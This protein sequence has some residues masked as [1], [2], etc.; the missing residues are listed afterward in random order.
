[1]TPEQLIEALN[2]MV[3][4]QWVVS[5]LDLIEALTQLMRR[6]LR[7]VADHDAQQRQC[8]L[9]VGFAQARFRQLVREHVMSL[10]RH[11]PV[12]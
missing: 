10:R 11:Q 12:M 6:P 9:G 2:P 3:A 4:H 7:I 8:R 1:M 5:A